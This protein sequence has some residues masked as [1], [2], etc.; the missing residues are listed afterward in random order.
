MALSG[1]RP[2]PINVHKACYPARALAYPRAISWIGG[3]SV[4]KSRIT[5]KQLEAFAYVVDTGTFRAAADA[6]GTTQPNISAR[7]SA[8]ETALGGSLLTRDSG[9][10]RLTER[11]ALVLQ[12]AREVLWAGEAL[13]EEAG[14]QDLIEE[15]LRLGVTEL[16]ACTWLQDFL[17][18]LKGAYPHL[19]VELQVDLSTVIDTRL[20]DG[21][22]DLALQT[23]PFKANLPA[24]EPLGDEPYC[25]VAR[26]NLAAEF[27]GKVPVGAMFKHPIITHAKHTQAGDALHQLALSRDLNRSQIVHSSALSA[28][29]PMV[30]EGLGIALLPEAL[31]RGEIARGA[32]QML[33]ADWLPDPLSFFARYSA[34][35]APRFVQKAAG[36]AAEAMQSQV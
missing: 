1:Y 25:W 24:S 26:P 20:M 6:L 28:C 23:G 7:I 14:R 18:L 21:Q 10:V 16:V 33:N 34:D 31:V 5:L 11:G 9:A 4:I 36:L 29:L 17:R 12:K 13:L 15:R 3:R 8:L 35:R 30:C 19:R 32:L 22:L 2:A 27:R